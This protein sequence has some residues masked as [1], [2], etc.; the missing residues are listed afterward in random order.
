M[1]RKRMTYNR[2]NSRGS[3][4]RRGKWMLMK[5]CPFQELIE[6]PDPDEQGS[7]PAG[8]IDRSTQRTYFA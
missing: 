3:P 5:T 7:L 2:S 4:I 8:P 1:G 6:W